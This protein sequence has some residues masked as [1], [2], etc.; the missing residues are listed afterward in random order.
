[1]ILI[2]SLSHR[3]LVLSLGKTLLWTN[4]I[5]F[6]RRDAVCMT[7]FPPSLSL[8]A[9][10]PTLCMLHLLMMKMMKRAYND[11]NLGV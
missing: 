7:G 5:C 8:N 2:I 10:Q 11:R 3:A 1:M 6:V 9:E 4:C